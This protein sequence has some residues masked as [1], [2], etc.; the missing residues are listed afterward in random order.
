MRVY[1]FLWWRMVSNICIK[2][3]VSYMMVAFCLHGTP[4]SIAIF[5]SSVNI[6]SMQNDGAFITFVSSFKIWGRPKF[7]SKITLSWY[8]ILF[9]SVITWFFCVFFFIFELA[10]PR[11]SK[12]SLKTIQLEFGISI[13]LT[14]WYFFCRLSRHAYVF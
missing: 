4:D 11:L 7:E 2:F 13:F 9:L 10:D 6:K 5:G 14:D 12:R 3:N 8:I 1:L